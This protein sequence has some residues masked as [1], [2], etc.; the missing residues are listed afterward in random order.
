MTKK[1][2][3]TFRDSIHKHLDRHLIHQE[4]TNNPFR[5]GMFDDWYSASPND[6]W[7]EYKFQAKLGSVKA[8]LSPLQFHWGSERFSE[9][10]N[11]AVIVGMPQ[12][13]IVLKYMEWQER[14]PVLEVEKRLLKRKQLA[15]LITEFT[16]CPYRQPTTQTL[17]LWEFL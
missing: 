9:G 13:G 3:N 17:E 6:L 7:I 8:E 15:E 4:K 14:I 11:V 10:R 16:T 12:G 1:A 2:E 5:S